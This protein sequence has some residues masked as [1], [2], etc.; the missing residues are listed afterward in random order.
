MQIAF[1]HPEF[2]TCRLV[3]ETAGWLRGPRLL[4][5]GARAKKQKGRYTVVSDTGRER[6]IQL[7]YNFLDPIPKIKIGDEISVLASPLKW[8]EYCWIGIPIAL[9]VA[10]GAIGGFC[11]A[12]AASVN[13]RIFR[14]DRGVVS[15]Y[16]LSGALTLGAFIAYVILATVFQILIGGLLQ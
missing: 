3:V 7:K 15:K 1:P 5:N 4:V 14:A 6:Q 16:L 10:G 11:G 2:K 8:Y 9:I 12:L 13:G